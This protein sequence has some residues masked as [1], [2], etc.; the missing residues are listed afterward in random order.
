MFSG[1][2]GVDF[3]LSTKVDVNGADT[4]PVFAFLKAQTGG[5]LGSSVKW[6]F[7][8]FLVASDGV[9]VKRYGSRTEPAAL[10]PEIQALLEPVAS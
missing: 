4:H 1:E 3:P 2:Q 5:L 9:T 10:R 8:K 7:T 6:N